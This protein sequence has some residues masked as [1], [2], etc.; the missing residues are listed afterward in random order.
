LEAELKHCRCIVEAVDNHAL[1]SITTSSARYM[2][3]P[4]FCTALRNG[5]IPNKKTRHLK[6]GDHL[7]TILHPV[8]SPVQ[9]KFPATS[10]ESKS[11][12]KGSMVLQNHSSGDQSA[13]PRG[14]KLGVMSEGIASKN[15]I[16]T[17]NRWRRP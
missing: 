4:L 17:N 3:D 16:E 13:A 2:H 8:Q 5:L 1:V 10:S 11:M 12:L 15:V 6:V 9:E 7:N 14:P